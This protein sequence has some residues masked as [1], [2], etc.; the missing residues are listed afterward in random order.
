VGP[1]LTETSGPRTA[2]IYAVGRGW[3]TDVGLTAGRITGRLEPI[4]QLFPGAT[5]FTFGFG[6]RAWL[7]A[8]RRG[9]DEIVQALLPAPGAILVTALRAPPVEAFGADH[10]VRLAVTEAGVD[11]LVGFLTASFELDQNGAPRLLA[12]GPYMGSA[13]YAASQTYDGIHTCNTWTA[14]ALRAAGVP[15][16]AEGVL[17]ASQVMERARAASASQSPSAIGAALK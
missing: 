1:P 11:R 7:L 15:V 12:A 14:E 3:H 4:R 5:G 6:A 13:F 10:V 17:F 8:A 9:L 2:T 16:S